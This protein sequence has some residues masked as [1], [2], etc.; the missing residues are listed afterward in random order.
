[1]LS[2]VAQQLAAI[3]TAQRC[4][5]GTVALQGREVPLSPSC[6]VFVT[7]NPGYAGRIE[8]P[9]NLQALFRPM[10]LMAPDSVAVAEVVLFWC[11]LHRCCHGTR[12]LLLSIAH[13]VATRCP[14]LSIAV[15]CTCCGNSSTCP[16][17][18]Q[19]CLHVRIAVSN[20]RAQCGCNRSPCGE[21]GACSPAASG[22]EPV[23]VGAARASRVP[24]IWQR[25]LC[26]CSRPPSSCSV[27]SATT[28]LAC[29]LS[30]QCSLRL[31]LHCT[32]N[33]AGRRSR[34]GLPLHSKAG[35]P[36]HSKAALPLRSCAR[37][38][39]RPP[40]CR[41]CAGPSCQSSHLRMQLWSPASPLCA[42]LPASPASRAL[43]HAHG[44]FCSM[45]TS[46]CTKTLHQLHV[47]LHPDRLVSLSSRNKTHTDC[48]LD[49]LLQ[50]PV[51]CIAAAPCLPTGCA[52]PA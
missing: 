33:A 25:R 6:G 10:A 45:R 2:V 17:P 40:L 18:L 3:Q 50:A 16:S 27:S 47:V 43:S 31:A 48:Q 37:C 35:L 5:A 15:Y 41:P 13:A 9:D 42:R 14:S 44:L 52:G 7:M 51:T 21:L 29:V 1:V 20:V 24:Q 39:K 22:H 30:R 26:T 11:E 49:M 32:S 19:R 12:C 8:L 36:L 23:A 28:T 4:R 38:R 46:A 34:L